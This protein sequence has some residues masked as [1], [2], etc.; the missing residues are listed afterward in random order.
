[1]NKFYIQIALFLLTIFAYANNET[2]AAEPAPGEDTKPQL[3]SRYP[4]SEEIYEKN[5]HLSSPSS[6]NNKKLAIE[7]MD[8][9]VKHLEYH[10]TN[11]DG[12]KVYIRNH[13]DSISYYVKKFDDKTDI[14]K[15]NLNIYASSQYNDIINKLWDP[16][17]PNTF[18]TG[19]VKIVHVYDPNLVIIQ[20][21]YKK[22]SEGHQKYFYALVGK[23]EISEG[24]TIIAMTSADI[25]DQNYS[26]RGNKN[27]IIK[28]ADSFY[29]RVTSEDDIKNGKLG[30]VFVNLAGYLI[31]KK[32]DDLEITYI[33]SIKG[34]S[35]I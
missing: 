5:K 16:N 4:T 32:G 28:K 7:L 11:N 23:A 18:N 20:Q 17:T 29:P 30:K 10:A 26:T 2:L 9:V 15:I 13:G 25:N 22:D 6:C 3:R 33:E 12:Y 21:R 1:M 19:S 8:E 31:E 27:P 35:S 14:L 34:H 24:K